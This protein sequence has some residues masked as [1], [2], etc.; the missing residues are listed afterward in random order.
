MLINRWVI[1]AYLF[2]LLWRYI[3]SEGIQIN[4]ATKENDVDR[5]DIIAD[6]LLNMDF[7]PY[8]FRD[9]KRKS[10]VIIEANNRMLHVL[11]DLLIISDE[12]LEDFSD[13]SKEPYFLEE[14]KSISLV[15]SSLL[16]FLVDHVEKMLESLPSSKP[17]SYFLYNDATEVY[18]KAHIELLKDY[19]VVT[20]RVACRLL[21]ISILLSS[22][23]NLANKEHSKSLNIS[24]PFLDDIIIRP[25]STAR[26]NLTKVLNRILNSIRN[27]GRRIK[28]GIKKKVGMSDEF[29]IV[30]A[31][32]PELNEKEFL[33]AIYNHRQSSARSIFGKDEAIFENKQEV[34]QVI[35]NF[36][37]KQERDSG[38][39]LQILE[40]VIR[41]ELGIESSQELQWNSKAKRKLTNVCRDSHVL[42]IL[43]NR[44]K[45]KTCRQLFNKAGE[46]LTGSH[47]KNSKKESHMAGR[48][49]V[50][51]KIRRV[52][53]IK[54]IQSILTYYNVND[55]LLKDQLAKV[56]K[57]TLNRSHRARYSEILNTED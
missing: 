23:E 38:I 52:S 9:L 42:E 32:S 35:N 47:Y 5:Y 3:I 28:I 56:S 22:L 37:G 2:Q 40:T 10:R 24:Y 30:S 16:K 14:Y 43:P 46:I 53:S 18:R 8:K 29:E 34:F 21:I 39:L 11:E 44:I 50:L 57:G 41:K 19:R 25:K 15:P 55:I 36:I 54:F 12:I 1:F 48:A 51:K 4:A 49:N 7:P 31:D 6:D 45:F 20:I 17:I 26:S 27:Y 33:S 13:P